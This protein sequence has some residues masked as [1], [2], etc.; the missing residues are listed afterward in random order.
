MLAARFP[1][2]QRGRNE[3]SPRFRA[4]VPQSSPV[5]SHAAV[6]VRAAAHHRETAGQAMWRETRGVPLNGV[7][8][9]CR[10]CIIPPRTVPA[11]PSV[12]G[13][14]ARDDRGGRRRRA[15]C[16]RVTAPFRLASGGTPSCQGKLPWWVVVSR[17]YHGYELITNGFHASD[18]HRSTARGAH[19]RANRSVGRLA[20]HRMR[21][22]SAASWRRGAGRTGLWDRMRKRPGADADSQS[23]TSVALAGA[24]RWG[25]TLT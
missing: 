15:A 3:R 11:S 9:R 18:D 4:R 19:A 21:R 24:S 2:T 23:Q 20:V 12:R 6:T 10:A 5:H 16:R 14:E 25:F 7:T 13:S 17:L 1:A 8:G 22:R